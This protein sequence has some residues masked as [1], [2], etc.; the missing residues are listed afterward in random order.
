MEEES[1][2]GK[3]G[4]IEYAKIRKIFSYSNATKC[5]NFLG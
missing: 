3:K 4:D 5:N 1:W 2:G